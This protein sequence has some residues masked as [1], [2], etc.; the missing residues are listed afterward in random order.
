MQPTARVVALTAGLTLGLAATTA[1]VPSYAQ[2]RPNVDG[3]GLIQCLMAQD[4][5]IVGDALQRC[6][7]GFERRDAAN[8]DGERVPAQR[9]DENAQPNIANADR[10]RAQ[11]QQVQCNVHRIT[12]QDFARAE[13]QLR[14]LV[15]A[16]E[17]SAEDARTRLAAMGRM[18]TN[19]AEC[20]SDRDRVQ[21]QRADQNAR[22]PGDDNDRRLALAR[23]L[24][25][26]YD[27]NGDGVV[28]QAE[29]DAVKAG[30]LAAFDADGD[31]ML[32]LEEYQAFWVARVFEW[33]VDAFQEFDANGDG[34]VTIEEFNA[35]LANI[36]ERLDQDGDGGFGR[37]DLGRGGPDRR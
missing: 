18:M 4:G 1:I 28:T 26:T 7:A 30:E 16:G 10:A 9:V 15:M 24:I 21:A 5:A 29:I 31:G 33:I 11:A 6:L 35:N 13:A 34:K 27:T 17:V 12:R 3:E 20:G 22:Q 8:A 19:Q 32:N 14:Q 37:A 36:V 2:D 23:E 25:G